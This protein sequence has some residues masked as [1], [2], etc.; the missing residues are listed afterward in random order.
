MVEARDDKGAVI[1]G[2]EREQCIF[3][4]VDGVRLPLQWPGQDPKA[5]AGRKV[6]LRFY[7]RDATI[8]AVSTAGQ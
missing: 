4:D 1:P 8:Y 7:F 3:R 5:L 6:A 2:F